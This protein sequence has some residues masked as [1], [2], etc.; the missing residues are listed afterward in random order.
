[1]SWNNANFKKVEN[2][3]VHDFKEE[4]IFVGKYL[5]VETDVGD[6]NSNMYHFEL[7]NGKLGSVWGSSVIDIRMKNVRVGELVKIEFLGVEKSQKTKRDYKNFD[8]FHAMPDD[9]DPTKE[10]DGSLPV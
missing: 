1:M 5:R 6:N 10:F 4:P 3:E 8:V 2:G 9:I 7:E